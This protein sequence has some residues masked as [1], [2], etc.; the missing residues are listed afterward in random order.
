VATRKRRLGVADFALF[1]GFTAPRVQ[2]DCTF[3]AVLESE[4]KPARSAARTNGSEHESH[5]ARECEDE[6]AGVRARALSLHARTERFGRCNLTEPISASGDTKGTTPGRMTKRKASSRSSFGTTALAEKQQ[7]SL[8]ASSVRVAL[9]VFLAAGIHVIAPGLDRF[10]WVF[11]AYVAAALG[12]HLAIRR[13]L[14]GVWRVL[15]GGIV[16]VAVITFLVHR[17]GSQGTPLVSA[18]LLLGMFVALVAPA[19]SARALSGLGVAC[20]GAISFAEVFR[21]IP[22]APDAPEMARHVP[23]L[24]GATRA[25]LLLAVL[26]AVSTWVSERIAHALRRRERQLRIANVRLEQLSQ[27]DPLTQLYNRRFF[28]HRV[29]EELARVRRGHP[30]AV[31]MMDLDGFKHVNDEQGHLAGD[32]LLKE[33]ARKVVQAMRVVDVVGRFGGDEF[34]VL[35]PDTD[36]SQAEI[37]AERIVRTIREVGTAADPRRPVTVS[38]GVAIPHIDDDVT[39]VLNQ[40]DEAAYAAKQDGGDRYRMACPPSVSHINDLAGPNSEV[41]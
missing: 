17:L 33:I 4:S 25:T 14:G 37:V 15:A 12:M 30:M 29:E 2:C 5:T 23:T 13:R 3:D 39:V 11:I 7:D 8:R 31:L 18:Y 36:S 20:Y 19:W 40:A 21:L 35:L 41:G 26:V 22:Y 16:D 10:V 9:A 1:A 34:V 24:L 28:V 38:V 27:R 6:S 32:T